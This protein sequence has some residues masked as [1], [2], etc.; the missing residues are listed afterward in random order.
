VVVEE[1]EEEEEEELAVEEE[2]EGEGE[3][4]GGGAAMAT[5]VRAV[6]QP[7]TPMLPLPGQEAAEEYTRVTLSA[8][9]RRMNTAAAASG[10]H[11]PRGT[12][13]KVP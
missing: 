10:V 4:G 7:V 5:S 6:S 8:G 13:E 9:E 12:L 11:T 1:E 3:E 2:R